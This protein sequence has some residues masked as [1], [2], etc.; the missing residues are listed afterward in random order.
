VFLTLF[1]ITGTLGGLFAIGWMPRSAQQVA[2]AREVERV[3][4][5]LPRVRVQLPR[6]SSRT[7]E[8][9][10]PG[11]LDALQETAIFARTTGYIRELKV[12]IGQT[13]KAGDVLTIIDT[14][15][16]D[17]QV[18][19]AT[20]T[21]SE[22]EAALE[23]AVATARLNDSSVARVRTLASRK[24]STQQELDDAEQA[25]SV[26]RARVKL[27]EA[28]IEVNRANLR[29][30]KELQSF[31]TLKAPFDGTITA[32][33]AE[34]GQLITA[35]NSDA[36]QL[37]RIASINPVR[38][39]VNVPQIYASSVVTGLEA[40]IVVRENP[41]RKFVGK[42]VRT[43]RAIDPRSRTLLTE[44]HVPNEDHELLTGAYV[45]VRMTLERNSPPLLVAASSLIF[46]SKGTRI[47]VVDAE[48]RVQMRTVTVDDD[49]GSSVGISSGLASS[50][51]VVVNPGD[52]LDEGEIVQVDQP[53][54]DVEVARQPAS[55]GTDDALLKREASR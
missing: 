40:E 54:G 42:V 10:L 46:D 27:A 9:L 30:V 51:R 20:A 35:G 24:V 38:V 7:T 39:F 14:P 13:V 29:R 52:R 2:L 41:N 19:Q 8:V 23:S 45:Q 21:L 48:Q 5:S 50:D 25:D 17:A 32:R 33:S 16:V 37:F 49:Y 22:S 43:A 3:K 34:V 12:D 15:E 4:T 1:A 36:Q 44:I 53:K 47:A 26:A 31:S 55:K 28:T 6:E 18:E 11:D